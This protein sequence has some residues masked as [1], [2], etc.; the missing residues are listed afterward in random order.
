M[1]QDTPPVEIALP[2][3]FTTPD[4]M[5]D[6]RELWHL[7]PCVMQLANVYDYVD[8]RVKA[9]VARCPDQLCTDNFSNIQTTTVKEWVRYPYHVEEQRNV[10]LY[11]ARKPRYKSFPVEGRWI[12]ILQY[13]GTYASGNREANLIQ[14]KEISGESY[15]ILVKNLEEYAQTFLDSISVPRH[16]FCPHCK[17]TGIREIE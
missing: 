6:Y 13:I 4:Y 2:V 12:S 10:A 5:R 9:A 14:I 17:G 7:Y 11:S 16:E 1:D 3:R 8:A 15:L